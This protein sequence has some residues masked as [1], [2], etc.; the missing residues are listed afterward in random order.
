MAHKLALEALNRTLQDVRSDSNLMGGVTVLL[1][2]DFR[3]THP[4]IPK[5]TPADELAASLKSS[6]LWQHVEVLTLSTN[7]RVHLHGDEMAGDFS[8]VLLVIG[9]GALTV[10]D[11][12]LIPVRPDWATSV[13]NIEELYSKVFPNLS[14]NYTNF[15]W[16][17][18]RAILAPRNDMVEITNNNLLSQLPGREK[19]YSSIDSVVN[20]QE[21]VNYPLEFLNSLQPSGV[22]P[23][24]LKLKIGCPITL[25]RNLD[26]PTL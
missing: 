4:V 13:N 12:G 23:H 8:G 9:N 2:G 20:P 6:V 11:H 19:V 21:A 14:P 26:V 15:R 3:Q 5:G 10:D 22:P 18:E 24:Q 16:L 17:C 25:L 7:M 1:A